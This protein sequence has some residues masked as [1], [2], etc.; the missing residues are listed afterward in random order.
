MDDESKLANYI[1]ALLLRD[2]I[3]SILRQIKKK[4]K[5]KE[6]KGEL[7]LREKFFMS[8]KF[9]ESFMCDIPV[10]DKSPAEGGKSRDGSYKPWLD[11]I[12]GTEKDDW[13]AGALDKVGAVK[14]CVATVHRGDNEIQN[15]SATRLTEEIQ[16]RKSPLCYICG[17]EC[18]GNQ[19]MMAVLNKKK[20]TAAGW[21]KRRCL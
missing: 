20:M 21:R 3:L 7:D 1:G 4:R 10:A 17:R 18:K 11:S 9:I 6:K 2:Y 13:R 12:F 19:Y 16:L 14:Q 8:S 5:K 15:L